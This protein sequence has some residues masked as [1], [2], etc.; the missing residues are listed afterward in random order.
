MN[1]KS[2]ITPERRQQVDSTQLMDR[3]GLD[4]RE[5]DRRKEFTR[6]GEVDR[7]RLERLETIVDPVIGEMVDAFYDHLQTFDETVEIF[8]RSSKNVDQL[9]K[10]QTRYCRALFAGEYDRQYFES[11]AR[12]GKIH[13]M[14]DLG[15]EI[16]LGAYSIYYDHMIDAIVEELQDRLRESDGETSPASEAGTE[17]HSESDLEPA[18]ALEEC[19][20][21]IRSI[22]KLT[23]LDQQVVMETY[24]DSYSRE[25]AEELERQRSVVT[26]IEG[27]VDECQT[28]ANELAESGE[29]IS[30][31][32]QQQVELINET[33]EEVSTLSATVEEVAATADDVASKSEQAKTLASEGHDEATKA[34]NVMARV[35]ESSQD[36]A[37]QVTQLEARIDEIDEIVDVINELAEETNILALNASIEAARAG[38]AGEGFA[39][40]ANEVKNLAEDSQTHAQ[41]IETMIEEIQ[42]DTAE[43]VAQLEAT[44]A[45]IDDGIEQVETA[46]EKLDEIVDAV[47]ETAQN[48]LEVSDATDEQAEST[49]EIASTMDELVE[50]TERVSEKIQEVSTANEEHAATVREIQETVN[51]LAE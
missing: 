20:D 30:E 28:L 19:G 12:I 41:E 10:T 8:G 15:P 37:E 14:L 49:S 4:Q 43:T 5:I 47:T 16:Y 25:L 33:A 17:N 3:L 42:S 29:Q 48:V 27:S 23:S 51:R 2:K 38:Q 50:R 13:D 32:A 36:A 7:R 46:M 39:V 35:N 45:E 9:K 26:E 22:L 31:E 6:F 40:V 24:V 21:L 18:E 44:T 1:S 11:R 34:I